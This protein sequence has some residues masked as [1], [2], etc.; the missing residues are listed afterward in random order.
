MPTMSEVVVYQFTSPTCGPCQHIKVHMNEL[1][2][3][4]S[5]Y[6]WN[7]INTK[8]DGETTRKWNVLSI[9]CTVVTKNGVEVG[10]HVGTQ[11]MRYLQILKH[12]SS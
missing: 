4:F 9:P 10:R 3:D 11:L 7:I 6:T 1:R 2:E 12:A 5:Q 8:E